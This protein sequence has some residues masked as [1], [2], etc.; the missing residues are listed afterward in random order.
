[1][2]VLTSSIEEEE[3]EKLE[4][5]TGWK[6]LHADVFRAPNC[7]GTRHWRLSTELRPVIMY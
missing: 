7:P 2:R 5:E 6:L 1:M 3:G 4:D